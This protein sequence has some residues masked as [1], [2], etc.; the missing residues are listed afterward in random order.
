MGG[1]MQDAFIGSWA[2]QPQFL[3]R[4]ARLVAR[5]ESPVPGSGRRASRRLAARPE[6]CT[7]RRGVRAGGAAVRRADGRRRRIAPTRCSI[8][9]FTTQRIGGRASAE[10]ANGASPTPRWSMTDIAGFV[11]FA[12]FYAWH[13]ASTAR[14]GAQLLLGM[15]EHTA[16]AFRGARL[17]G[18]P[19]LAAS[20][21]ANL[22]ARWCTSGAYWSALMGAASRARRGAAARVQLFGVQLGGRVHACRDAARGPAERGLRAEASRG[23]VYAAPMQAL[24]L[25]QLTK[26]Y[27][28]GIRALK[29]ID[30]EVDGGRLLRAPG[31]ERRRQDDRH[32]H[33][34]LARQQDQRHRRGVRPRYRS[35]ARSGEVLHRRGAAGDQFQHVRDACSRS[36]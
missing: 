19:A 21:T 16:A 28:N 12:L 30:L 34:H 22:S 33:R 35:R 9:A 26:V 1:V 18:L 27:K 24:V 10:R 25:R 5:S 8:C 15:T 36:W 31:P 32:R 7:A 11:R 4:D 14:L 29:G 3:G 20:E 2:R 6:R 23:L 17:N 13:V